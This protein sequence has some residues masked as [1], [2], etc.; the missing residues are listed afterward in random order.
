MQQLPKQTNE[1]V[2][3]IN[4]VFFIFSPRAEDKRTAGH[5]SVGANP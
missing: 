1:A 4:I 2:K 3:T 5:L